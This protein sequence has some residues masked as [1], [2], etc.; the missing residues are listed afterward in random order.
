M[1][2]PNSADIRINTRALDA[3]TK[4]IQE[5]NKNCAKVIRILEALNTNVVEIGREMREEPERPNISPD[6]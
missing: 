4:A 5:F 6:T 1:S 2:G 3:N